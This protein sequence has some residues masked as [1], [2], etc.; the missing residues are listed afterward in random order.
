MRGFAWAVAATVGAVSLGA[1]AAPAAAV[2]PAA[3]AAADI[4]APAV[5]A[6]YAVLVQAGY[7]DALTT[8][9]TMQT[10]INA[11]TAQPVRGDAWPRP[12]RPGS[13]RARSMAR[14]RPSASTAARS[15]TK[16]APKAA[17]T[18]GRWTS[19]TST[20][21]RASPMPASINDRKAGIIRK[22]R[23]SSLNERGGEENIATGWHAIEFLLWGQDLNETG[24]GDRAFDRLRRRQGAQRRPPPPVPAG[25][26]R[27]AG[28]R[29]RGSG[30]GLG[31]GAETITAPRSSA[32][33]T[34]SVRRML[35]RAGVAVARRAGRRAAR[36][37]AGQPGPGGRALAASPT[38]P[39]ATR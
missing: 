24:P 23:W 9:T 21:S 5:A 26:H 10:A 3:R 17:S 25:G 39:T 35:R 11:L 4:S 14:P 38:T 28:R 15:T 37:R 20:T 22:K 29:P 7:Q 33:G 6:H 12:A 13:T 16:A 36:G 1:Q 34:E 30:Q 27:A 8:A 32:A 31:A 19:R 2:A 18:P